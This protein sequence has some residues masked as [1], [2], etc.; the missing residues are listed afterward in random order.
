MTKYEEYESSY[1]KGEMTEV[2]EW[3]HA[4]HRH[5]VLQN[6]WSWMEH[7]PMPTCRRS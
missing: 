5:E 3:R 6:F 4:E 2:E 7:A 1:G